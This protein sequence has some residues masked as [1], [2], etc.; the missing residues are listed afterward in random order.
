MEKNLKS[1]PFCGGEAIIKTEYTS[2]F[3]IG[4]ECSK[5]FAKTARYT[6]DIKMPNALERI[7]ECKQLAIEAWNRRVTD[8]R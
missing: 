2:R 6:L 3:V 1:C 8:E 5:C 7:D 4:C